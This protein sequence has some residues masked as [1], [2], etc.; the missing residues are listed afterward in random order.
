M[1]Y[2]QVRSKITWNNNVISSFQY[3]DKLDAGQSRIVARPA[4]ALAAC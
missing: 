1:L 3:M 4:V 2:I